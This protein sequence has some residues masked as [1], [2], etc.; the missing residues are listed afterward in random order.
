M[1]NEKQAIKIVRG[2]TNSFSVTIIDETTGEPY[3]LDSGEVIRFG[4]KVNPND[5]TY[6]FQK[7]ISA[8]DEEDEYSFTINPSDTLSLA[9]GSYWY[10]I[11]LQSGTAYF[12][13][14]PA[15]PFELAYNVTKA[16]A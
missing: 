8:A 7:T 11:G 3:V 1:C 13:I 4:V 12:N 14:I 5:T 2:T 10:D 16:E 6:L 15:S 9:F